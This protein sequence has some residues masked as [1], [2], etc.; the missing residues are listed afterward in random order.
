MGYSRLL[1]P[2]QWEWRC[3]PRHPVLMQPG[4]RRCQGGRSLRTPFE[5]IRGCCENSLKTFQSSSKSVPSNHG[6]IRVGAGTLFRRPF[7]PCSKCSSRFD[8]YYPG[9]LAIKLGKSLGS[10]SRSFPCPGKI[11]ERRFIPITAVRRL[12]RHP[13][14]SQVQ[15]LALVL[16][17][18][19]PGFHFL[20]LA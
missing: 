6:P 13:P 7:C 1:M 19:D 18:H 12:R 9:D 8:W 14:A 4:W 10:E 3:G 11:H 2:E 20:G 5:G 16:D 15:L 17:Q